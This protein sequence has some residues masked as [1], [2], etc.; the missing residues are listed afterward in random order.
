LRRGVTLATLAYVVVLSVHLG[1][2]ALRVPL[3]GWLAAAQDLTLYLFLPL[4]ALLAL[5]LALRARAALALAVLPLAVF[6]YHYAPQLFPPR[7][8]AAGG[9]AS[10]R[11]L[12]F[13][14]SGNHGRARAQPL[15]ELIRAERP[16]VVAVQEL[17]W[18]RLDDVMT[19][20][21]DEYPYV[22][23]TPDVA[24]ISRWPLADAH[25]L[26]LAGND[27]VSQRVSVQ[28]GA[29]WVTLSNV[30][31]KRPVSGLSLRRNLLPWAEQFETGWRDVPA[32]ALVRS[33]AP[34]EEP[35]VVAG[36]FNQTDWSASYATIAAALQ[37]SFREAGWG[38]GHTYPS[39][40]GHDPWTVSVPLLRLDYVFHS[41]GL[42]A[43][44]A[45]VG[46]AAGSYHLPVIVDLQVR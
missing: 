45:R 32:E 3:T 10:L 41:A 18:R 1:A 12:T 46:P 43:T 26:W 16:D 29:R 31:V 44:E 21:G 40:I 22:A 19:A 34:L 6:L 14:V 2:L 37:D 15:V 39:A 36:D 13:N 11:L 27:Y 30:H 24:T 42:G 5:G 33:L 38:F 7:A 4:P 8:M 20:V 17:P 28:V 25:D 35:Q 9:G 23:R